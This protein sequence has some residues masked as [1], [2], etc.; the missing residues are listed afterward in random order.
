MP[1]PV[2]AQIGATIPARDDND[3]VGKPVTLQHPQDRRPRTGLA[4]ILS[5]RTPCPK[6]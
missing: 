4:I 6:G 3:M 1:E 2:P 5:Q